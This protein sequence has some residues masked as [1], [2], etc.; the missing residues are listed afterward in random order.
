M[1]FN[2]K[3][4]Y[5]FGIYCAAL[6]IQNILALKTIDILCFTV[7]T[8]VLVSPIVFMM[9]DVESEVYGYKRARNMILLA[10]VMNFVFTVLVTV[11][12]H[13]PGSVE[14]A[15]QEAFAV[16]FGTTFRVTF[17]SFVAYVVG[18]LVNAKIMTHKKEKHGLAFRAISSTIAGQLLD[19]A[20]FS[21]IAFAGV[22]PVPALVS[23]AVGATLFETLYEIVFLPVTRKVIQKVAAS[24][25]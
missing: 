6:L 24:D 20:L 11:A 22:L 16:I 13:L 2:K 12:I 25:G 23:M 7:T 21:T 14:F 9:Q 1:V 19:N 8:G 4:T 17:A 18:S 10:Y 3:E 15:N 5:I